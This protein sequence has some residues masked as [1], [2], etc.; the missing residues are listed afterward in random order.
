MKCV[1]LI[2]LMMTI[3]NSVL[4]NI[5]EHENFSAYKYEMPNIVVIFISISRENFMLT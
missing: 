5:A 1:L 4:L 2:N 3:A